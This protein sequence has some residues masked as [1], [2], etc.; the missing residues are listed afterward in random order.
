MAGTNWIAAAGGSRPDMDRDRIW[1][2]DRRC[3]SE[4][5]T[6]ETDDNQP[7]SLLSRYWGYATSYHSRNHDFDFKL[8]SY[9]W[10][11]ICRYT[12]YRWH[13]FPEYDTEHY[14]EHYSEIPNCA[15]TCPSSNAEYDP[16]SDPESQL[17][18]RYHTSRTRLI[19][20]GATIL[21]EGD[22]SA[23]IATTL[24]TYNYHTGSAGTKH[25]ETHSP[26][27]K[28]SSG[29]CT[30][31]R[32]NNCT[33][34]TAKSARKEVVANAPTDE[35]RSHMHKLQ[36]RMR[37]WLSLDNPKIHNCYWK[38]TSES[39]LTNWY[40]T[41]RSRNGLVVGRATTYNRG[42]T[43]PESNPSATASN[44]RTGSS[45]R[46][47]LGAHLP[48]ENRS[49]RLVDECTLEEITSRV[50]NHLEKSQPD[51]TTSEL[52][53][54]RCGYPAKW[55]QGHLQKERKAYPEESW[56]AQPASGDKCTEHRADFKFTY[57][58]TDLEDDQW[59]WKS[60]GEMT[61][62]SSEFDLRRTSAIMSTKAVPNETENDLWTYQ[63]VYR[64]A[65]RATVTEWHRKRQSP[66]GIARDSHRM[67]SWETVET[68]TER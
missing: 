7:P 28:A 35:S 39:S 47:H 11:Q 58:C 37:S 22:D 34:K 45:A 36:T 26:I 20:G 2:D 5:G 42:M 60:T 63:I 17:Q 49:W 55:Q 25:H 27:E 1:M 46:K 51:E 12:M 24:T 8:R 56:R 43:V 54:R 41:R 44:H 33:P 31:R 16:E 52:R 6:R 23:G 67:A 19:L 18:C 13:G 3:I 38:S 48:A 50:N 57:K 4:D 62:I 29:K 66:N 40:G 9:N 14:S 10:A 53:D 64:M 65:S 30:W 61:R 32:T 21:K 15:A 68:T 59:N